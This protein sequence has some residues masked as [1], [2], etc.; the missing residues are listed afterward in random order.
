MPFVS[1]RGRTFEVTEE[2]FLINHAD[3][4]GEW[5]DY[6]RA[7]EEIDELEDDHLELMR[8][9][10]DYHDLNG[11]PPKVKEMSQHTGFK[12]KRIYDLF[13]S[14]PGKGACRMAGLAK[15]DGCV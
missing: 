7:Q 1:H 8:I 3:W 15:P 10:R 11:H 6:V 12:L 9:L 4:C 13:P 2:G 14:G 5:V